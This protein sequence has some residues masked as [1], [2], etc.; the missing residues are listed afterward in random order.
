MA[1]VKLDSNFF[2]F[3]PH[4][5]TREPVSDIEKG[6]RYS[7]FVGELL[8]FF[9]IAQFRG[10]GDS[11]DGLREWQNR[12]LRLNTCVSVSCVDLASRSDECQQIKSGFVKCYAVSSFRNEKI[13]DSPHD[14]TKVH[15]PIITS[16]GDII[17]PLTA[18]LDVLP[19]LS[20]RIKLSVNVWTQELSAPVNVTNGLQWSNYVDYFINN[21]PDDALGDLQTPFRCHVNA[22]LPVVSPPTVRGKFTTATGKHYVAIEVIN[23]LGEPVTIHK[24]SV[25]T[26]SHSITRRSGPAKHALSNS[27]NRYNSSVYTVPL[28]PNEASEHTP[29]LLP[30]EHS[31]YLFR[32]VQPDSS[33]PY[34]KQRDI[35]LLSSVT[36]SVNT[37]DLRHQHITTRYSL[38]HLNIQR[39]SVTV[40]ASANST[41]KNGTRFFVNYTVN[42]EDEADFNASMLWQHNLGTHL[43]PGMHNIDSNSL[44]CLQPSLKLGV[45]SGCSQNFQVEFLAVQ[46]GLHEVGR[47]M[48]CQLSGDFGERPRLIGGA[49]T[50]SHSCQVFVIDNNR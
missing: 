21:D 35:D 48:V 27:Q 11:T 33:I 19:A 12:L 2:I 7:C 45:P 36:W 49:G 23:S 32:I 30:C 17:Y 44:I 15:C 39:S 5:S 22:T 40:K 29:T 9:L 6:P 20:K 43:M 41:I 47:S 16:R 25:H 46:E 26:S 37:L 3:L 14:S 13:I 31:T 34:Q 8:H 1:G 4:I 38:P 10:K 18:S 42:N 28:L 50:L 24:V